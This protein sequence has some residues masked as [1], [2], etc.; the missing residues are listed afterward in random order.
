MIRTGFGTSTLEQCALTVLATCDG[1]RVG[2]VG[3]RA[4]RQQWEL[5]VHSRKRAPL[6]M[7]RGEM[8]DRASGARSRRSSTYGSRLMAPPLGSELLTTRPS[9]VRH[10]SGNRLHMAA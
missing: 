7:A 3:I 10:L 6:I 2:C 9:P 5:R 8:E 4:P 1:V